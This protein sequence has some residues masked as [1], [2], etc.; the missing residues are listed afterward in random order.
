MGDNTM[1]CILATACAAVVVVMPGRGTRREGR[2]P[3][4]PGDRG[5]R[6]PG[7]CSARGWAHD[8]R[9]PFGR[10]PSAG[11][12]AISGE[13]TA[14]AAS[15]SPRRSTCKKMPPPLEVSATAFGFRFYPGRRV[16]VD[17]AR[18]VE[19]DDGAQVVLGAVVEPR[20]SSR[21]CATARP[22]TYWSAGRCRSTDRWGRRARNRRRRFAG[23]ASSRSPPNPRSL[24]DGKDQRVSHGTLVAMVGPG[25]AV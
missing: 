4:W 25:E 16:A 14:S 24:G 10:P 21:R 11:S 2:R 5:D 13:W 8:D 12:P 15:R 6:Q 9:V 23:S 19:V 17:A 18:D 7:R 20:T 3:K 22:G 1:V